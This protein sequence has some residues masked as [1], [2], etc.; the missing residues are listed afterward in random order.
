M[1]S[2]NLYYYFL[3][4]Y[5]EF[6]LGKY[7]SYIFCYLWNLMWCLFKFTGLIKYIYD[8]MKLLLLHSEG[9]FLLLFLRSVY[10]QENLTEWN[11]KEIL[12]SLR[13]VKNLILTD[14][15]VSRKNITRSRVVS[16][17]AWLL[18]YYMLAISVLPYPG[19]TPLILLQSCKWKSDNQALRIYM[20][21]PWFDMMQ[22]SRSHWE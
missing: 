17:H 18:N 22:F 3:R 4:K 1:K 10:L 7:K 11:T 14:I 8:F 12:N 2:K 19:N 16:F 21:H 9:N 15:V 20:P 5:A 13:I 6:H